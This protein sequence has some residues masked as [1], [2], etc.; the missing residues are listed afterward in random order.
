MLDTGTVIRMPRPGT[1]SHSAF[2]AL[3]TSWGEWGATQNRTAFSVAS[4]PRQSR[5]SVVAVPLP[6]AVSTRGMP[7][8]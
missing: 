4:R 7:C 8:S 3:R 2:S 6:R 1:S 5:I